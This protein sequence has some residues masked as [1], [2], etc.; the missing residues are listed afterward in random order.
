MY[1]DTDEDHYHMCRVVRHWPEW[2]KTNLN[3]SCHIYVTLEDEKAQ[4]H[5]GGEESRFPTARNL[6]RLRTS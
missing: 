4:E 6:K 3:M 2:Y 1:A 5:A